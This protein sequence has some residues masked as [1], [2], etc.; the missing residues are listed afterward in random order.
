V[1]GIYMLPL[2]AL[3]PLALYYLTGRVYEWGSEE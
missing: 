3:P 1:L 2:L